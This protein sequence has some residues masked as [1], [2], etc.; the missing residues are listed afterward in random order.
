MQ[1]SLSHELEVGV[2]ASVVWELYKGLGIG[3]LGFVES[4]NYVANA[5]VAMY[6]HCN[7]LR[8]ARKVFDGI[9]K[10][11]SDTIATIFF[12]CGQLRDLTFG[13][14]VHRYA[15]KISPYVE[16]DGFVRSSLVDLYGHA[17]L[18]E[19]GLTYFKV[20]DKEYGITPL[21][22]NHGSVVDLLV[23]ARLLDEAK[24]FIAAMPK[25]PGPSV[26][27]ALLGTCKIYKE[28]SK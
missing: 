11:L 25:K 17:G 27:G 10:V 14:Q 3:K 26:W 16:N 22:E 7:S 12:A 21:D 19:E 18:V 6:A 1:G 28:I 5:P 15:I 4:D 24:S 20:M 2:P 8:D 23:P 9:R 13:E